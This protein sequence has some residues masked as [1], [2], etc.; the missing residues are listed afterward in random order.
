MRIAR[1]QTEQLRKEVLEGVSDE[2]KTEELQRN[3]E[4]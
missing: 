1:K 2:G 3:A 4:T